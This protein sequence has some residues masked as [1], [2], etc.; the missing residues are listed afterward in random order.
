MKSAIGILIRIALNLKI[1]VSG[2]DF[3]TM[4]ILPIHEHVIVDASIYLYLL[5]FLSPVSYKF[6][7]TGLLPPWLILFLSSPEDIF[8]LLPEREKEERETWMQERSIH[9]LPPIHAQ[10][11]DCMCLDWGLNPQPRY[12]PWLRIKP[13]PSGYGMT[14]QQTEPH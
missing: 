1:A 2:L 8:S 12:V 6:L 3:I 5:Q 9:W 4:L 10:T 7:S 14:L 11:E 13:Q